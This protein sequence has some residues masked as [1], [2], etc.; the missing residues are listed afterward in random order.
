MICSSLVRCKEQ[1]FN[2]KSTGATRTMRIMAIFGV[3]P[4]TLFYQTCRNVCPFLSVM[5]P[6]VIAS[7][8]RTPTQF[9]LVCE[10]FPVNGLHTPL[11]LKLKHGGPCVCKRCYYACSRTRF[12]RNRLVAYVLCW[13]FNLRESFSPLLDSLLSIDKGTNHPASSSYSPI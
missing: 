10:G 8:L 11:T 12:T 2:S 3:L 4:P 5:S 1:K 6:L 7:E 13:G 9:R